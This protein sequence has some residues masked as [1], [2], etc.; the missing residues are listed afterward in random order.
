MANKRKTQLYTLEWSRLLPQE[1]R[2]ASDMDR[3][4]SWNMIKGMNATEVARKLETQIIPKMLPFS[5]SMIIDGAKMT[6]P[7]IEGDDLTIRIDRDF[8]VSPT[9]LKALH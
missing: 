6:N 4:R 8:S 3:V 7:I 1:W 2:E 5:I 9:I